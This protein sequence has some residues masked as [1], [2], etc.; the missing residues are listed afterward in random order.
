MRRK[1]PFFTA[2][3]ARLSQ[4][5]SEARHAARYYPRHGQPWTATEDKLILRL[6][7]QAGGRPSQFDESACYGIAARVGCTPMAVRKRFEIL[8][9]AVKYGG[10]L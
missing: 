6:F 7:Q 10:Q 4:R 2:T 9:V 5:A 3:H 8:C 1:K